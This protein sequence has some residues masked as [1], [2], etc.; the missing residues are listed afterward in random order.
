MMILAGSDLSDRCCCSYCVAAATTSCHSKTTLLADVVLAFDT[1]MW[2]LLWF[3]ADDIDVAMMVMMMLFMMMM[4]MMMMLMTVMVMVMVMATMVSLTGAMRVAVMMLSWVPA[5]MTDV[6]VPSMVN[7]VM[8]CVDDAGGHLDVADI[9]GDGC[10]D[11]RCT[12]VTSSRL[13]CL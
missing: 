9:D 10:H 5:P 3:T 4:M 6:L 12:L 2:W 1:E 13:Q 7:A 8:D 11:P